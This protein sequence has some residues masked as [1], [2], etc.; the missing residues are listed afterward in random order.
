MRRGAQRTL[1]RGRGELGLAVRGLQQDIV[2]VTGLRRARGEQQRY[3]EQ[4]H[5]PEPGRALSGA[6]SGLVQAHHNVCGSGSSKTG[7]P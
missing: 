6:T 3:T 1:V 5:G 7:D 4:R 2:R